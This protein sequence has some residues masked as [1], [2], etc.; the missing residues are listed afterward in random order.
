MYKCEIIIG[1]NGMNRRDWGALTDAGT[2]KRRAGGRRR[3][4]AMRRRRVEARR[5]AIADMLAGR[6]LAA[7]VTRGLGKA[8]AG[9]FGVSPST[10]SRDLRLIL[11]G[12][13]E[14]HSHG[15]DGEFQFS[16]RRAYAGGPV[17]SVTDGDGNEIRGAER[18]SIVRGLSRYS[19]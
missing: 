5:R 4:N 11:Y 19:G 18:R 3:Y 7:A 10:I 17:L 12:G 16:V 2:A 14:Y 13:K 15:P 6:G 1:E 8:L 9:Q